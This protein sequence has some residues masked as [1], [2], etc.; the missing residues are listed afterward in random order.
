M[1]PEKSPRRDSNPRL[2]K[3]QQTD[4]ELDTWSTSI[5]KS[6]ATKTIQKIS[7][8]TKGN[9]ENFQRLLDQQKSAQSNKNPGKLEF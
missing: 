4:N 1:K 8:P 7:N 5:A 2:I 6:E 3:T 9:H